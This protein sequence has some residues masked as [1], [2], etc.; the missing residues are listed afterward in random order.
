MTIA[1]ALLQEGMHVVLPV[2]RTSFACNR[3]RI[4]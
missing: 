4:Q 1:N 2:W 3:C